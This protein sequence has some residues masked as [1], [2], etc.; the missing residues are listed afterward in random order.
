MACGPNRPRR[1]RR[2]RRW[3]RA[4][5][6]AQRDPDLAR[7]Q[8]R[9]ATCRRRRATRAT[10]CCAN[11]VPAARHPAP[12]ARASRRRSGRDR[13]DARWRAGAA[14]TVLPAWRQWSSSRMCR[15]LRPLLAMPRARLTATLVARGAAGSTIRAIDNA[16]IARV[17]LRASAAMLAR[18]RASAERLAATAC[19]LARARRAL[20][21]DGATAGARRR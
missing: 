10:G 19:R 9:Q 3:L 20:E 8:A 21:H 13:G 18:R 6:I 5:G 16:A 17:R 7:R 1:R 2:S 11:G 15:L 4:H 12:A 14:P